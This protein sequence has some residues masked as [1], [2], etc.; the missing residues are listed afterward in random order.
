M[1]LIIACASPVFAKT[2]RTFTENSLI[3]RKQ[4]ASNRQVA[5]MGYSKVDIKTWLL[6]VFTS[7][8][9]SLP[10]EP[11]LERVRSLQRGLYS[12][13][14]TI[15]PYKYTQGYCQE[16]VRWAREQGRPMSEVDIPLPIE[17]HAT[18]DEIVANIRKRLDTRL[19]KRSRETYDAIGLASLSKYME[20]QIRKHRVLPVDFPAPTVY[21]WDRASAETPC[22]PNFKEVYR[23]PLCD[24]NPAHEDPIDLEPIAAGQGI[25]SMGGC[26]DAKNYDASIEASFDEGTGYGRDPRTRCER[27]RNE[28]KVARD[29]LDPERAR[30]LAQDELDF[31]VARL[32][33]L[34][35]QMYLCIPLGEYQE[36]VRNLVRRERY[37]RDLEAQRR[38]IAEVQRAEAEYRQQLRLA[39]ERSRVDQGRVDQGGGG[40]VA[41]AVARAVARD[42]PA[43][44]H[45]LDVDELIAEI[46]AEIDESRNTLDLDSVVQAARR[47]NAAEQAALGTNNDWMEF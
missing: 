30:K 10:E 7:F 5:S 35:A 38:Q 39:I 27:R 28:G 29:G 33:P 40:E 36:A 12:T 17:I 6:E 2:F 11:T 46:D 22:D 25:C 4:S 13:T 15:N 16:V 21:T 20:K 32:A 23:E 44:S 34:L 37:I 24:N 3:S 8:H 42:N 9:R 45:T 1:L 43:I 19:R 47:V 26:Y 14:A 41:G 18:K 31:E